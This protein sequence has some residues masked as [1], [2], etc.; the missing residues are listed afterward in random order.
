MNS[1]Q[2]LGRI[3]PAALSD[4]IGGAYM[5]FVA[6]ILVGVMGFAWVGVTSIPSL[7]AFSVFYGLVSGTVATLPAT[8]IPHIC[9]S[10]ST[11]GTRIGM[12]YASAGVGT[13]IGNP[14]ALAT[15]GHALRKHQFL[16]SQLWMG[17]CALVG[18]GFFVVPA[19]TANKVR[20]SRLLPAS[21]V[22]VGRN[23]KPGP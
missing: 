8:V 18:A 12:I 4:Y 3:V 15:T 16:G 23:I 17:L 1:A 10:P 20:A 22:I 7:I 21:R 11:L 9:P 2:I 13:L 19:I 6:M 5:L 14:V